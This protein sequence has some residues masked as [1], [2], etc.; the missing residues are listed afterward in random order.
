MIR[1]AVGPRLEPTF[2]LTFLDPADNPL[3]L[4]VEIDTGFAGLIALPSDIIAR[5]ALPFVATLPVELAD[6]T[7]VMRPYYQARVEWQ[8]AI[9]TVRAIEM[10]SEPLVGIN[11]LWSQRVLIDVV[12]GGDVTITPIP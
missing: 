5:L 4:D 3:P 1:G 7:H 10:G 9:R 6:G 8:Q 2:C 12:V 11:F